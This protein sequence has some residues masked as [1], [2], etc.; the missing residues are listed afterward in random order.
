MKDKNNAFN[1]FFMSR[2]ALVEQTGGDGMEK[3]K[4][5]SQFGT[6]INSVTKGS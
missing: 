5:G 1:D 2:L 6:N 4:V 3:V